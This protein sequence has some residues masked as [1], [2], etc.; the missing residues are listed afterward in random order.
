MPPRESKTSTIMTDQNQ[1]RYIVHKDKVY[2]VVNR[3]LYCTYV[4]CAVDK[5]EPTPKWKG[6][7][8][9]FALWQEMVAWCQVTQEKFKS[10]ALCFLFLDLENKEN[11]WSVWYPPQKTQG[12]T[13]QADEDHPDYEAQRK[14]Y[15]D[16]QFGT[17]HHHCTSGAFASGTDKDDE[18]DR[19]GLHFTIGH[20]GKDK[21][22][23]HYRFS[24]EGTCFEGKVCDVVEPS[25]HLAHVPEK[26]QRMIHS[27]MC[28]D[29]V[30]VS[31][32]DFTKE[33]ENV[34]KVVYQRRV[35]NTGYGVGNGYQSQFPGITVEE[36]NEIGVPNTLPN[37]SVE[38]LV[39]DEEGCLRTGAPNIAWDVCQAFG[40]YPEVSGTDKAEDYFAE[41]EYT[42]IYEKACE[43]LSTAA[44]STPKKVAE[45]LKLKSDLVDIMFEWTGY[46]RD[47]QRPAKD[48]KYAYDCYKFVVGVAKVWDNAA[49]AQN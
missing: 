32:Y 2:R 43:I 4:E 33:L 1:T 19:E 34:T 47:N 44:S 27:G 49:D 36:M 18:I 30:D 8:I 29:P 12:M 16:I 7:K 20:V 25:P 35:Y 48:M 5:E 37:K 11:P 17:L 24:I 41:K 39:K 46:E 42:E 26:Y 13:V 9:P 28:H 14:N 15:P 40:T 6:P 22:D 23:L 3:D 31:K 45:T 21:H 10:E 38:Q